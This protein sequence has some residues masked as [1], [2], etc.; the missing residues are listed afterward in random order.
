MKFR[1]IT[2]VAASV[3]ILLAATACSSGSGGTGSASSPSASKT[4]AAAAKTY[5]ASDLPPILTTAE[6]SLG[7]TGTVLDDTQVQAKL[8][9]AKGSNGISTLLSQSGVTIS[10]A[11]CKQIVTDNLSATPP[12][13]TINSLLSYGPSA[14]FVTSVSGKKLPTSL[15]T[16][17][18]SKQAKALSECG[19]MKVSVTEGGQ[20]VTIPLTIKKIDVTTDADQTYAYEETVTTPSATGGA[21][22]PVSIEIVSAI[23]GNLVITAEQASGATTAAATASA[24]PSPSAADVINAVI[25]AAKK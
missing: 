20:T 16:D 11:A 19:S 3:G 21:G 10:P 14:V 5:T 24:S 15:T 4:A 13:G 22:T 1:T 2:V 7:I 12:T 25:A 23:S 8:K 18:Q 9:Q 17:A 6:K